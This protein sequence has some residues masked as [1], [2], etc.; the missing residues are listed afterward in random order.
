SSINTLEFFQYLEG[1]GIKPNVVSKDGTTALHALALRTKDL[2]LLGYFI[3]KGVNVNQADANGVTAFMNAA[4]RNSLEV[5]TYLSSNVKDF[6]AKNNKD[7][8]ALSL[9]VANN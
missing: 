6:N 5:V 3:E 8:T 2:K 7:E 1:L 9:A 4:S